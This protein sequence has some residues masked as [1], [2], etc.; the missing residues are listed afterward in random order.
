[1]LREAIATIRPGDRVV[2]DG[3]HQLTYV[4]TLAKEHGLVLRQ[5]KNR[6]VWEV[7]CI[8]FY[9]NATLIWLKQHR[10]KRAAKRR[11]QVNN[12]DYKNLSG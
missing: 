6:E 2:I 4:R 12:Y 11:W 1:M 7:F 3:R 10:V 8:G 9:R 5:Q